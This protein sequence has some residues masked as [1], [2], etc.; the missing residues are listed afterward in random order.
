MP[1]RKLLTPILLF[2]AALLAVP[3]SAAP[4]QGAG[5]EDVPTIQEEGEFYVINISE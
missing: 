5:D 2:L 3:A 1:L 4:F